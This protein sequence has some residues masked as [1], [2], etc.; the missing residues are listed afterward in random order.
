MP[1]YALSED[2]ENVRKRFLDLKKV[3]GTA[4]IGQEN[5]LNKLLV[6]L[7]AEG[8]VLLEGNPG[9]AK[10][11]AVKTLSNAIDAE[12]KRIQFTPDLL[13][14]DLIGTEIY[15]AEDKTFKTLLGP[16]FTQIL[17]AD[18][19]NRAPP[20]VQS[21]LLEVM[22]EKQVTLG[23]ERHPFGDLFWVL[24]TQNP[25]ELEGTYP[26]PEAQLDRFMMK[27]LIGYPE[28][29]EELQIMDLYS[30]PQNTPKV[31]KV[32]T[33][34]DVVEARKV[35]RKIYVD[36]KVQDYIISIVE[37]TRDK[38]RMLDYGASPRASLA[39]MA[40]GRANA[41]LMGRAYV[42]PQDIKM[43]AHDILR[44]RIKPSY[45]AQAEDL[46]VD[47]IIDDILKDTPVP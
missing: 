35:S 10:T 21:A 38:K 45:E 7:V 24:G 19:I 18:E 11:L 40:V 37:K 22:G 31:S 41:F 3:L 36:P 28:K 5:L 34:N 4:V 43:H 1:E 20:K 32:M 12:Y 13:P 2:A 44:H 46:G 8:H 42:T 15:L 47:Q 16:I 14:Q 6:A 29:A 17:L 33:I 9:L 26:L 30:N 39:F 25:L 23:N 27:I